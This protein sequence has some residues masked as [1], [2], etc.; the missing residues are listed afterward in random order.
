MGGDLMPV[1]SSTLLRTTNVDMPVAIVVACAVERPSFPTGACGI[2][3][4]RLR[5]RLIKKKLKK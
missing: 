1:P 3:K 5:Q 2:Y 4:N